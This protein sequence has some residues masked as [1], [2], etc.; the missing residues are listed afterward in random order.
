M[1]TCWCWACSR[2]SFIFPER[3]R[4]ADRSAC[5]SISR[6]PRGAGAGTVSSGNVRSGDAARGK[7][8]VI[9]ED[10]IDSGRTMLKLLGLLQARNRPPS[11]SV[12]CWTRSCSRPRSPNCGGSVHGTPWRSSWATPST[13][14]E[15]F[16]HL[17]FIGDLTD[18]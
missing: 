17:P 3:P 6:W 12:R 1:A 7:H 4:P 9:V 5:I 8:I 14:P 11:R 15:D 16:R 2:G 13:T 18:G 10:I